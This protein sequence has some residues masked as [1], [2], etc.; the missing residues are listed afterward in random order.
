LPREGR[1]LRARNWVGPVREAPSRGPPSRVRP[2]S[3][4]P[5]RGCEPTPLKGGSAAL[6]GP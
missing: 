5:Q 6:T 1:K 2:N 4:S 3:D